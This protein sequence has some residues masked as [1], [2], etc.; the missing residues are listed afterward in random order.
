MWHRGAF[1]NW[2]IVTQGQETTQVAAFLLPFSQFKILTQILSEHLA[3]PCIVYNRRGKRGHQLIRALVVWTPGFFNPHAKVSLRKVLMVLIWSTLRTE[4]MKIQCE[5]S[6][7]LFSYAF[8]FT[9]PSF[10]KVCVCN[11]VCCQLE[12]AGVSVKIWEAYANPTYST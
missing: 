5:C 4:L 8:S 11:E 7:S 10:L 2:N 3:S 12:K 1:D 6:Q 9:L